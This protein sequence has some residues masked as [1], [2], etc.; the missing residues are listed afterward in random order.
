[1]ICYL[2]VKGMLQDHIG[3]RKPLLDI[4]LAHFDMFEQ[5]SVFMQ[6]GS[7]PPCAHRPD[8]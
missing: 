4:P 2:R 7:Y 3:F 6:A 5:V 8:L 1:M